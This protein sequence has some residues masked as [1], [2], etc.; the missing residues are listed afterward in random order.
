M[1]IRNMGAS[2]LLFAAAAGAQPRLP[3]WA[4]ATFGPDSAAGGN[5][6]FPMSPG[7]RSRYEGDVDGETEFIN[8]FTTF[9]TRTILGIETRVV[10][11]TAYIDGVLVEVADDW[12]AR[13]TDG[14]VWYFGEYVVNYH[15]DDMGNFIGI[16]HDGSWIADGTTNRPGVIMFNAPII[17]DEYYQ[18]FAPGVALD[19]ARID[20]L[21]E[22]VDIDYGHYAG[23]LDTAEG[24]LVDGPGIAERKFY[25]VGTGLVQIRELDDAGDPEF[26]ID[27]IDQQVIPGPGGTSAIG[28]AALAGFRRRR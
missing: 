22:V 8:S 19:F 23:V 6:Y 5:G 14:N 2:A 9:E 28:L 13:D 4:T 24:N 27:L 10:R 20:S 15:Y 26:F 16:D 3:D 25:A 11:D 21:T 12:F 1:R 7:T 18:E 17:G